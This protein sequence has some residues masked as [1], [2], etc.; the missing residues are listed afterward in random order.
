MSESINFWLSNKDKKKGSSETNHEMPN[1]K[2]R[3]REANQKPL[4][5]LPLINLYTIQI[6]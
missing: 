3:K 6:K 4:R 5:P 2:K 1:M